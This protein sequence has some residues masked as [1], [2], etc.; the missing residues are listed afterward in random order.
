M[1]M[2]IKNAEENILSRD[3]WKVVKGTIVPTYIFKLA[4]YSF[5]KLDQAGSWITL[6]F[7]SK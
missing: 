1:K 4:S 2:S 6:F 3:V 5:K 7:L